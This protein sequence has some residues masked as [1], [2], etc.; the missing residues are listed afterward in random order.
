MES[1]EIVRRAI[2]FDAPPRLPF[3]L[4]AQFD[5]IKEMVPGILNDV[6]DCWEMDRQQAGWFFDNPVEDDWGCGWTATEKKNMGQVI[7]H[8]LK[9]FSKLDSYVPPNPRNPF[10]Y[11]RLGEIIDTAD[12]RYVMVTSHFNLIERLHML[13]GFEETLQDLYLQSEKCER[14]LDMIVEFKLAQFDELHKRFSDKVNGLF[15]T[16]DWGTQKNTFIS[17]EI[18]KKY[19]FDR[20]KIL[21]DAIHGYNWHFIL[22]SCGRVNDFVPLFIDA[23]VDVLNMQQPQAYGIKEIGEKFAGKICFLTTV[24]IQATLPTGNAELVRAEAAELVK[25]WST[26][27]GGFIVFNYGDEEGIGT[28]PEM[29]KAMF[30]T[31]LRLSRP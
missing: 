18:F 5:R 27:K 17:P 11:K 3:F 2:E 22:H 13:H 30:E 23:G 21:A 24:D 14:I 4:G 15:L 1:K 26:S 7:H 25:Y 6:C 20:Y 28:S 9:D 16:D 12:D 29:T 31:F 19:F 8:P 10:Y